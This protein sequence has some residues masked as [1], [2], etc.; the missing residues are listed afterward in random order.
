MAAALAL[1]IAGLI[2]SITGLGAA[3]ALTATEI[4]GS[5]L[6]GSAIGGAVLNVPAG[7]IANKIVTPEMEQSFA[8][9]QNKLKD[10]ALAVYFQ[11]PRFLA[12]YSRGPRAKQA[13][14]EVITPVVLDP[15]VID[16]ITEDD[17]IA[18]ALND[19]NEDIPYAQEVDPK[20]I[21]TV[22]NYIAK[23]PPTDDKVSI[24]KY[25]DELTNTDEFYK[26]PVDQI[27]DYIIKNK[28][29]NAEEYQKIS[30][31]YNMNGL[32]IANNFVA[33]QRPDGR[34]DLYFIDETGQRN[35]PM[36]S[37]K[38]GDFYITPIWGKYGGAQSENGA[39]NGDP[40]PID[41]VD[42]AFAAH[43]IDYN[44]NGYFSY[45]ADMKLVSRLNALLEKGL[46]P[47]DKIGLIKSIIS[48]FVTAGTLLA[49]LKGTTND[50]VLS[51]NNF[52]KE[53]TNDN[54]NDDNGD[55]NDNTESNNAYTQF[56]ENLFFEELE[57]SYM[58]GFSTITMA[59]DIIRNEIESMQ[60]ILV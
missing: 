15:D 50:N 55:N 20:D 21:M 57:Q 19:F 1:P 56:E 44:K 17:P 23:K 24:N 25:F 51:P 34:Y 9:N 42:L 2:E 46:V 30:G 32:S 38:Q 4:T 12:K 36:T 35:G 7:A 49:T 37:N 33:Q 59:D 41:L 31:V 54:N 14:P 60:I 3:T 53:I 10:T 28:V 39:I 48:Y 8:Y 22:I 26:E 16:D 43:D 6:I 52:Y 40:T 11:N 18:N 29:V 58:D 45:T 13:K 27:T 47:V 5:Q